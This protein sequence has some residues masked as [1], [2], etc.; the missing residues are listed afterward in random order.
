MSGIFNVNTLLFS[1]SSY[2]KTG[3]VIIDTIIL[4]LVSAFAVSSISYLMIIKDYL[5]NYSIKDVYINW[6]LSYY[7]SMTLQFERGFIKNSHISSTNNNWDDDYVI[8]SV[9]FCLDQK[10][11][12]TSDHQNYSI[13]FEKDG[14]NQSSLNQLFKNGKFK[15]QPQFLLEYQDFFIS[16]SSK[17]IIKSETEYT[18]YNRSLTIY[19]SKSTEEIEKFLKEC[20]AKYSDFKHPDKEYEPIY[21]TK[22]VDKP[23]E[24]YERIS[25]KDY[26]RPMN[27]FHYYPYHPKKTKDDIFFRQKEM[28]F[29]KYQ[30]FLENPKQDKFCVLLYGRPGTGKTSV[31]EAFANEFDLSI[32]ES[33]FD[34]FLDEQ[35]LQDF[36][37]N[38]RVYK[39]E[40]DIR[41]VKQGRFKKVP[42]DK[43]LYLF[44]DFDSASSVV[45]DRKYKFN[46]SDSEDE[47]SSDESSDEDESEKL[48]PK[49]LFDQKTETKKKSKKKKKKPKFDIQDFKQSSL[50]DMITKP[51]ITLK[52]LLNIFGGVF[53]L[54]KSVIF[55]TTNHIE[56]IDPALIRPGRVNI[57][58][59]MGEIDY[60][61]AVQMIE[62]LNPEIDTDDENLK[63]LLHDVNILPCQLEE[64]INISENTNNLIQYLVKYTKN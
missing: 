20:I 9:L 64:L 46:L 38:E 23:W 43:R 3:N 54:E 47:S 10:N 26:F 62:H 56:V 21:A 15:I 4:T 12:K 50:V 53:K 40:N 30:E 2:L 35:S 7:Y 41:D 32:F 39:R 33:N 18:K 17:N 24:K 25:D 55:L 60:N 51:Q 27:E 61:S 52:D 13:S 63:I 34:S 45:L 29:R 31:I 5:A 8:D 14:S 49:N 28:L 48:G 44:E 59:K 1:L 57:R 22:H 16:Y 58:I 37:H 36:F 42:L 6:K 11:I 19:S